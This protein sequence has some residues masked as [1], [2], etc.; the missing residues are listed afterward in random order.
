MCKS[1][2][3]P[4]LSSSLISPGVQ[5]LSPPQGSAHLGCGLCLRFL[6]LVCGGARDLLLPALC[7]SWLLEPACPVGGTFSS[8]ILGAVN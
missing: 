3:T 8:V 6:H 5:P 4:L 7:V 1:A 2:T